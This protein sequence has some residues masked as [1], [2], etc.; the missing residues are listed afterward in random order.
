MQEIT[1]GWALKKQQLKSFFNKKSVILLTQLIVLFAILFC[2]FENG[3][4]N[5]VRN[6]LELLNIRNISN[7]NKVI[8]EIVVSIK[9]LN[10]SLQLF[11]FIFLIF[12][13]IAVFIAVPLFILFFVKT[14]NR[15]VNEQKQRKFDVSSSTTANFKAVYIL[16]KKFLC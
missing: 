4:V 14:T 6:C 5:E 10:D 11:N 15:M 8:T 13:V 3:I 7:V 1:N 12:K 9:T 16:Q 2:T